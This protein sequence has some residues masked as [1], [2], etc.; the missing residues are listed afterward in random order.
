EEGSLSLPYLP[1]VEAMRSYVLARE[2]ERLREELGSGAGEVARIVS[3]IR[4]RLQVEPSPPT[5]DPEEERYRLFQ[6]VAGFLRHASAVQ[7]LVL[8][9][10]DLHDA[11]RG[12]LDLLTHVSHNLTGARLL[13]VGTYRDI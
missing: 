2:P 11:D 4:E 9:L 7:P 5:G 13:V 8:V 12:T 1:F 6:A 10:E 3:E